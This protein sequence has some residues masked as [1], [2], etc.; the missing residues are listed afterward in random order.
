MTGSATAAKAQFR[1]RATLAGRVFERSGDVLW[2]HALPGIVLHHISTQRYLELDD[3]GYR[4]WALLDGARTAGEVVD[5]LVPEEPIEECPE[6]QERA[7]MIIATLAEH[8]FVI[9]RHP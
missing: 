4:T 3:F 1:S 7:W 9:E 2:T 8:G 6:V 5:R